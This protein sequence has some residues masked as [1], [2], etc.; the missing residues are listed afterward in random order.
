MKKQFVIYTDGASRG[1]PGEASC[2]YV[3]QTKDSVIWVQDG[4]YLGVATNNVA[5]YNGVTEALGRLVKDF[6]KDLP[7]EVE[8]RMDSK[9]AVE[10]LS[11]RYK[12]KN[13]NLKELALKVRELEKKIGQV[14]YLHV[15]RAQNFLADKLA[16]MV[17]DQNLK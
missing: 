5:E 10:Q 14:Q 6:S 16:N 8:I 12:I 15:P 1:N 7:T 13:D 9:L 3:I 11:G 2:G 17:L 4:K